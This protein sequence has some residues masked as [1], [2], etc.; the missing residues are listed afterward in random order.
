[1][2]R[3]KPR[4]AFASAVCLKWVCVIADGTHGIDGVVRNQRKLRFNRDVDVLPA[5]ETNEKVQSGGG[6]NGIIQHNDI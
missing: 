4:S 1:M 5:I 6:R 2:A 3:T